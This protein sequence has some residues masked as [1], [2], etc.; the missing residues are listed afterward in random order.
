MGAQDSQLVQLYKAWMELIYQTGFTLSVVC[1]SIGLASFYFA[2][3]YLR[4]LMS[5]TGSMMGQQETPAGAALR[6][7]MAVMF[8]RLAVSVNDLSATM[9][10]GTGIDYEG[11][12]PAS[13][14]SGK[15]APD[16]ISPEAA[17][18][19]LIFAIFSLT[20]YWAVIMGIFQLPKLDRMHPEHRGWGTFG[21]L[22]A[23]IIGGIV[24]INLEEVLVKIQPYL[25]FL[26]FFN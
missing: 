19:G 15:S 18:K 24:S 9:F 12:N 23:F 10:H 20:G 2:V 14:G 13:W 5:N 6:I 8:M 17:L 21:E 1:F 7:V 26:S 25:P 22:C 4:K 11:A 16:Y 3:G